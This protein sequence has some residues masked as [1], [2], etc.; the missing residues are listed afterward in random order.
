M[1][2]SNAHPSTRPGAEVQGDIRAARPE[3]APPSAEELVDGE[4]DAKVKKQQYETEHR[5]QVNR[6][7]LVE[8]DEPRRVRAED[9]PG[10]NEEGDRRK[11]DAAAGASKE[12]GKQESRS[13]NGEFVVH[14][15]RPL[16]WAYVRRHA[17]ARG[18][19]PTPPTRLQDPKGSPPR[20]AAR[21]LVCAIGGPGDGDPAPRASHESFC[22][23]GARRADAA[24]AGITSL[25]PVRCREAI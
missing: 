3:E 9:D 2:Q 15:I 20:L 22:Q 12:S 25:P 18:R 13:E 23:P 11:S 7:G 5:E 21:L 8:H 14:V 24:N 16:P 1:P 10:D 6:V 17:P 4:L 19:Q